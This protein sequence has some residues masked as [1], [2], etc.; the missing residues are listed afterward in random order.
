[1]YAYVLRHGLDHVLY[2][3][4]PHVNIEKN[5]VEG[6]HERIAGVL[7]GNDATLLALVD[8]IFDALSCMFERGAARH[9]PDLVEERA[10]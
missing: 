8:T 4:A 5:Q 10:A 3:G 1:L 6:I 7:A 2:L 9:W